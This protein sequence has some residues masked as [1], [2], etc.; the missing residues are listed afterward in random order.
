MRPPAQGSRAW[1]LLNV[2]TD[3]NVWLYRVSRGWLGGRMGRAPVL[4]LH[5]RGR[6][7]GK[8]R[9]TPV[10]Y[11]PDGERLVVVASRGGADAN[12]AWFGNLLAH[13][14]T[15]VEVGRAR[16]PVV[17]RRATADERAAYWPR[18]VE[19]YPSFDLYRRRTER[20]IPVVV[21]EPAC[22]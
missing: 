20:E 5:H 1:R 12:P 13:P 11:L 9:V 22:P 14:R 17:A 21:L 15:Q 10:L 18:L 4:L 7:T 19:I 6:K 16:R 8:P 3:L 2:G